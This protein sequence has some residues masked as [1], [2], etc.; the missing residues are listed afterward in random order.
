MRFPR[1]AKIFRGQI[2]AAPFAGLF[3]MLLLMLLL[4][5][6]S[7]FIPGI[8]VQ[9]RDQT[10]PELEERTLT[11]EAS[12][13]VTYMGERYEVERFEERLRLQAQAGRL[14]GR[15]RYIVE[16]KANPDLVT[17][18]EQFTRELGIALRPPGRRL[19]VP[20]SAGF[21]G[22]RNPTVVVGINL[23]GQIFV[24]QRLV[25]EESLVARLKVIAENEPLA[26]LVLQA[27]RAVP[28]DRIT[29]LMGM[30]RS[31]GF[32]EVLLAHGP[33]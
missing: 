25:P 7:I 16:P 30:A 21:P 28:L 15:V 24:Q 5:G 14:P 11:V 27:D 4:Y 1:N 22:V 3:F 29:R 18:V 19:E 23:N 32:A 31:A 17:R 13:R 9:L 33:G 12:G 20:P 2:D 8:R 26:T 6:N 10:T